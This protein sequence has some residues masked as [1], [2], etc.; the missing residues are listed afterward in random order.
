MKWFFNIF[1]AT[2]APLSK[3][4]KP[5]WLAE[6][7]ATMTADTIKEIQKRI[8]TDPDG[9]W[10]PKSTEACKR[11]L[12]ALM[13][14]PSPWPSSDDVSMT[15]FY[16]KAGDESNLVN[17]D[18]AGLG[19]LYEGNPV[20]TVRVHKKCAESLLRVLSAIAASPHAWVL[21]EYAGCFNFRPMRGGSRPSKHAW[22]AAIDLVPARNGLA[23]AWPSFANMPLEVMEMFAA[24]GWTSAG[25][26]WGKDAMHHEATR[27]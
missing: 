9:Q 1:Y 11:H 12:R 19:I 27:S 8:G 3:Q 25:A 18:V 17:L 22:G 14:N 24:E 2:T 20:K 6:K 23:T 21:L 13:P 16:G 26:F 5:D 7:E 15:R 4:G 10:G